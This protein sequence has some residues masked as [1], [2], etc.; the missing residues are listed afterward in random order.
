MGSGLMRAAA[1]HAREFIAAPR[2]APAAMAD[3]QRPPAQEV[4]H[5]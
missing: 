3:H 2:P 1:Y 4:D 5:E